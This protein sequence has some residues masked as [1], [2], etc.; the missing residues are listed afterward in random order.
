[1][2]PSTSFLSLP[3][4]LFV[5]TA[6]SDI[7]CGLCSGYDRGI[8]AYFYS[9]DGSLSNFDACSAMCQSDTKCQSFAFGDSQCLLYSEPLDANFRQQSGSPFLFYDRTCVDVEPTSSFTTILP[10]T[11][12]SSVASTTSQPDITSSTPAATTTEASDGTGSSE[13]GSVSTVQSEGPTVTKA[14]TDPISG[15][16]GASETGSSSGTLETATAGATGSSS[17]DSSASGTSTNLSD[18]SSFR[19]AAPTSAPTSTEGGSSQSSDSNSIA[20]ALLCDSWW[21]TVLASY[22]LIANLM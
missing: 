16:V 22:C 10:P 13:P 11:T 1:M 5:R 7:T 20:S 4:L 21:P 6:L 17:A 15:Q 9:G 14:T 12:S 19:T 18:N 3:L 2:R 8:N